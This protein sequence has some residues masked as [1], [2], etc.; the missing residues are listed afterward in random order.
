MYNAFVMSDNE[1][2][3]QAENIEF[4]GEDHLEDPEIEA[5]ETLGADKLKD[6]RGKLKECNEQRSQVLEDL[7]RVKAD[8]LNAK[9]RLEHERERDVQ[10]ATDA[11]I[12]KLLPLCDSF[13]MAMSDEA[14]WQA[15]S[16]E[17]RT[18]IEGI[19]GQLQTILSGFGVTELD[20]TG[21]VFDPNKHEAVGNVPVSDAASDH[22]VI[23]V[24]QLGYERTEGN[25]ATLLRPARVTVG[26]YQ[27]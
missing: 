25:Y 6:L 19:Y 10:R 4:T 27:N 22:M 26:T 2:D 1:R 13:H 21:E 14:K 24:L 8:F 18:G 5:I 7:Q 16:Q 20:P 23:S 9:K 12:T 11:F 15:V 17:W 3:E